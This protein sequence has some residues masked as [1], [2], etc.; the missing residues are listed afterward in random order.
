MVQ[1]RSKAIF[2]RCSCFTCCQQGSRTPY[3]QAKVTTS[4]LSAYA[5]PILA[6]EW[7][8]S[9]VAASRLLAETL[10]RGAS[11]LEKNFLKLALAT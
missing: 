2:E 10:Y 7:L 11:F 1:E 3:V 4:Y 9:T 6:Q 8:G 5:L